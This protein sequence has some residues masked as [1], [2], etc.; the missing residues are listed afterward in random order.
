M[1]KSL[2]PEKS[3]ISALV[4]VWF[5]THF[6]GGFA[7]GRQVVEYFTSFGWYAVFM[8][9]LSQF[10]V[11]A[12]LYFAWKYAVERQLFDYRKWTDSYFHPIQ[13][14]MS[15]AYE[16]LYNL[17]LVTAT[18]VAF[19]TGG[20]TLKAVLGTD[21]MVNTLFIAIALLLL[22][23][24]GAGV[25]R[26]AA[27]VIAIIIIGGM[28]LIYIP[29]ILY[30]LPQITGNISALRSGAIVNDRTFLQAFM[31]S[32]KYAGFQSVVFGAYIVHARILKD[33]EDAKKAAG[34]GFLLNSGM[35]VL[36]S[37]GILAYYDRGILTESIPALFVIRNGVGAAWM[38]PLVSI[39]VI[40]G[41]VSTGV[42]LIYGI[43][44]R[45]VQFVGR[46]DTEAVYAR[47]ERKRSFAASLFYV[48]LTWSIAQFGLIPL[49]AKGYGTIGNI[50]LILLVIPIISK[51]LIAWKPKAASAE[52]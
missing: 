5:T 30:T 51:G 33:P 9:V 52:A 42:N 22:T 18:A 35:L 27:T 41:A 1:D 8:P 29:N 50:A 37:L 21:Y 26:K 17:T 12:V 2:K 3:A 38:V 16:A 11:G 6:G 31:Q 36:T 23:V 4:F 10:I 43:S 48:I 19:A 34:W 32:V 25:V 49:V 46:N 7:S 44:N 39:L 45:I 28:L 47:N 24:F 40:L 14:F 20:A 13:A 15:N